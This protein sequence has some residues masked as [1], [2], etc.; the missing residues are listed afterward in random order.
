MH[1][2]GAP[3]FSVRTTSELRA[4]TV[5]TDQRVLVVGY[6]YAPVEAE[7]QLALLRALFRH[8]LGDLA[9]VPQTDMLT[10]R[11]LPPALSWLRS[12]G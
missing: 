10:G 5:E 12:V 3:D 2:A 6:Q 7:A 9:G 1:H 11:R 4:C 8:N